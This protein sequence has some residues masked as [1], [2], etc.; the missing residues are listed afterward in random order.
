MVRFGTVCAGS[1][2]YLSVF[3]YMEEMFG[4]E[5]G[6]YLRFV[7]EYSCES[8]VAKQEWVDHFAAKWFLGTL[9]RMD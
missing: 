2:V 1:E 8:E 3:L 6:L 4:E 5:L 9:A 7:Q